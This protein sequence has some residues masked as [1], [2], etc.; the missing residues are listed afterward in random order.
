MIPHPFYLSKDYLHLVEYYGYS[1]TQSVSKEENL[2]V[3]IVPERKTVTL[4]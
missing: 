1:V 3:Q 4:D 2:V